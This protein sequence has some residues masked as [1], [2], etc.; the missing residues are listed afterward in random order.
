MT[1]SLERLL[2]RPF[3]NE[4]L[5]KMLSKSM[6]P[7][8]TSLKKSKKRQAIAPA[9]GEL[10]EVPGELWECPPTVS[11]SISY[12][13]PI[14]IYIYDTT[15]I[16]LLLAQHFCHEMDLEQRSRRENRSIRLQIA[17]RRL[18]IFVKICVLR[19]WGSYATV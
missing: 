18:R 12:I 6:I 19:I 14:Y 8:E 11:Y 4:V 7:H 13:F 1:A 2:L 3:L 10:W 16:T 5:P 9:L 17:L 15:K